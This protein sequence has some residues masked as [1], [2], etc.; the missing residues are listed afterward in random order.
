MIPHPKT[1]QSITDQRW[2]ELQIRTHRE[3]LAMTALEQPPAA[4]FI[5]TLRLH[6]ANAVQMLQP[7]LA[8]HWEI[9]M[10]RGAQRS[11]IP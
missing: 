1:M 4:T 11:L 10:L 6:V 2:H 3:R 9:G 7:I 5:P 8:R